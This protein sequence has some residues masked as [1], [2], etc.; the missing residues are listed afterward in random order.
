MFNFRV[1]EMCNKNEL[2]SFLIVSFWITIFHTSKLL[3][4]SLFKIIGKTKVLKRPI[5]IKFQTL[6]HHFVPN[7]LQLT[8]LRSFAYFLFALF[9]IKNRYEIFKNWGGFNIREPIFN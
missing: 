8:D 5:L 1:S 2:H 3:A 6:E 4:F 9:Y 7:V